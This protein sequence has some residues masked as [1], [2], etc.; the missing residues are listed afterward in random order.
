MNFLAEVLT[1]ASRAD[2]TTLSHAVQSRRRLGLDCASVNLQTNAAGTACKI[3]Q[4]K[5]LDAIDSCIGD[6]V[7]R[8]LG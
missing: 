3:T 7:T 5:F 2:N 8:C 6:G 1:I 4:A